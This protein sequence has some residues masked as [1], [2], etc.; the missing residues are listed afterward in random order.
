MKPN[1]QQA[2][3]CTI[4]PPHIM[5]KIAENGSVGDRRRIEATRARIGKLAGARSL[6][7]HITGPAV[8][9][10]AAAGKRRKVY[11]AGHDVR[12]PGRLV[13]AEGETKRRDVAANEAYD[14][15]GATYDFYEQLFGRRSLDGKS[16]T[17]LSTVHYGK[18]FDNA[19]WNGK[20]VIY[21]DGDGRLFNR[22]T[23]AL[24]VI[25]HEL[26]HGVTQFTAGLAYTGQTGALNEHLSDVFGILVKQHRLGLTAVNRTGSSAPAS[27]ARR[28]T[29]RPSAPWP[30]PAR[31][32]T[33][34]SSASIRSRGICAT[35]RK[36]ATIAAG[37]TS[38]PASP[39][40]PSTWQPSPSAARR[41]RWPGASGTTRS[42][43]T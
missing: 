40:T 25:G 18:Q 35:T 12:L 30:P 33:T 28:C 29:A 42:H 14:G 41:G 37:C 11:D 17:I 34:R 15:A 1:K 20:Q 16:L 22:F 36:R 3:A 13:L 24:D 4:I 31:P 9:Q 39:I 19:L 38:T 43:T 21:G 2:A 32:T 23:V 6:T 7:H 10:I 26:A 27:S 8:V 5:S